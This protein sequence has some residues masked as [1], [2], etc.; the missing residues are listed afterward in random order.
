MELLEIWNRSDFAAKGV[1]LFVPLWLAVVLV[2]FYCFWPYSVAARKLRAFR[3]HTAPIRKL[4]PRESDLLCHLYPELAGQEDVF[5]L[6]GAYRMIVI[7]HSYRHPGASYLH[8]LDGIP[9]HVRLDGVERFLEAEGNVAEV[10]LTRRHALIVALNG[11]YRFGRGTPA[12]GT[13]DT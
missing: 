1:L 10:V 3:R 11:K 12:S 13:S 4:Q 2:V 5:A 8:L 9:V 7:R 6:K